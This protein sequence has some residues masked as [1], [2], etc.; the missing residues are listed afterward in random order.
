M[1]K[2]SNPS[3]LYQ[4]RTKLQRFG[5]LALVMAAFGLML[6][7]KADTI[8]VEKGRILFNDIATPVLALLSKPAETASR[9]MQ[10]IHE[11]VSIR[12][13]NNRLREENQRLNM[14]KLETERL[15]KEAAYLS[16]LLNYVPPPE[17]VSVS[18]R[19]IAD[20]GNSFAQ[21]LIAFIGTKQDIEKGDVVLTGDG[22]VGRVASVGV[23]AA[24]ILLITDINSRVPVKIEPIDV[25]AILTG[26]NTEYPQLIS[27][28]NNVRVSVGDRVTTS[29]VAGVYPAG[30]PV[31]T[32]I[33]VNDG[34]VKVRPF[35][36]RNHLEVVRI[37]D[38]GLSG[39][40]ADPK[41]ET[42]L[43]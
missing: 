24:R 9:F 19:V 26:D 35:V 32:V 38:Y 6:L 42:T 12:Q 30:L 36:D 17:A 37:V 34:V 22:L 8:L 41:C 1:A 11:L 14:I 43:P 39:L 25:P 23:N 33:S 40:I 7:G 3:S 21:S 10:N 5:L 16:A 29:G 4:I 31:G 2:Q 20:T 28:P 27:F 18:A 15:R 13:E